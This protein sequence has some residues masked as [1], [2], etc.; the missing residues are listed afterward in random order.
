LTSS[1]FTIRFKGSSETSDGTQD[2]W[3]ID[4]TLLHVWSTLIYDYVL[5]IVNQVSDNWTINLRVYDSSNIGR[6]SSLNISL[7]DGASSNQIAVSDGSIVKSEGDA[8]SLV[9]GVGVTVYISMS[10]LSAT[11]SGTSSIYAYLKILTP[12]T[13][14]YM[15]YIIVFEIT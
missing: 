9:G 2:S 11:T 15:Q 1:N 6:L 3:K 8:Y 12:N 7:H 14:I 5:R 10:N 4:A 13:S